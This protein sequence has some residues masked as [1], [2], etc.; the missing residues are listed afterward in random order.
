M[1]N[2][3]ILS[4]MGLA[5]G[6]SLCS[7]GGSAQDVLPSTQQGQQA[8]KQTAESGKQTVSE[9]RILPTP[10][11]G[12]FESI[13]LA[14]GDNAPNVLRLP[15]TETMLPALPG[16]K[17]A[18]I[19]WDAPSNWWARFCDRQQ[20]LEQEVRAIFKRAVIGSNETLVG[21]LIPAPRCW[22]PLSQRATLTIEGNI[23]DA[24]S[25][26]SG[27]RTLFDGEV[28]VTVY[29]LPLSI[30]LLVIA[31]IYPGY[32]AIQWCLR[33]REFD[34]HVRSLT[35]EQK[36][37]LTPPLSFLRALDP[38][39]INANAWG[40]ASLGKLQIFLFTLIVFGLLF[41]NVLRRDILAAMSTDVLTLLGISA[42]GAVGG[43]MAYTKNRRLSFENFVWLVRHKWLPEIAK[44]RDI[45][46][47]AKWSELFVDSNTKEFDPYSFQMAIFSIVVGVALAQTSF[48]GFGAFH[49]PNELLGLLGLSH[50]VFVGGKALEKTGYPEL[51]KK[52]DEVREHERNVA[53]LNKETDVKQKENLAKEQDSLVEASAQAAQMFVELYR[54]ELREIPSVVT[55]AAARRTVA[56]KLE[57][58][59]A[60]EGL[61]K[62]GEVTNREVEKVQNSDVSA[63]RQTGRDERPKQAESA[64]CEPGRVQEANPVRHSGLDERLKQVEAVKHEHAKLQEAGAT[65]FRQADYDVK[66]QIRRETD[67]E[68]RSPD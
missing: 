42:V 13:A 65:T 6:L 40:R 67:D 58:R 63:L 31:I 60:L 45:V 39:Q 57:T 37:R 34:R 68:P 10:T 19:V 55:D 43:K 62:Q 52:L 56:Y 18:R 44:E 17:M 38:V 49:I 27:K 15:F 11:L 14:G 8:A 29:W 66:V 33:K 36:S 54:T 28:W 26:L 24:N 32:A 41:F 2:M 21:F 48:T 20:P 9:Q 4:V 64:N 25:A 35:A 3:Q 46:P 16:G 50:V 22:L 59:Q 47:Y 23:V 12:N 1:S 5:L 30:T 53:A 51:D 61:S 7:A